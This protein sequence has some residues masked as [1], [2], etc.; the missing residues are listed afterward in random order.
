MSDYQDKKE[1]NWKETMKYYSKIALV[2]LVLIWLFNIA[3]GAQNMAQENTN[4][5]QVP[6]FAFFHVAGGP[7]RF[8]TEFEDAT[9]EADEI[10]NSNYLWSSIIVKN[11]GNKDA[12]DTEIE[13]TTAIPIE[14]IFVDVAGYYNDAEITH[15]ENS[16]EATVELEDFGQG[17]QTT[18]FIAMSPLG[19]EKPY[20]QVKWARE[21]ETYLEQINVDSDSIESTYYGPGYSALYS[22]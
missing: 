15:E 7:E 22:N 8:T 9:E 13:L 3:N 16:N 20:D 10:K 4:A 11:N 12:T 2:V 21:Y 1:N 18:I 6:S 14:R 17:N 19:Y 5:V